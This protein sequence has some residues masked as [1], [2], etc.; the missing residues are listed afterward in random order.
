M[1]GGI[2]YLEAKRKNRERMRNARKQKKENEASVTI[3]SPVPLPQV[4]SSSFSS[5]QTRA[6][7]IKRAEKSLPGSPRKRLEIIGSL[8]QKYKVLLARPPNRGRK[9]RALDEDQTAWLMDF[10]DRPDITLTNPGTKESVY[11]G[12]I[13]GV[14]QFLQKQYLLWT[15]RDLLDIINGS[16]VSG[17]GVNDN[18]FAEKFDEKLSLSQLYSFLKA[19]KQFVWNKNIPEVSCLCEVCENACLFAKGINKQL[20][21]SLPTNPH[22]LVEENS[23]SSCESCMTGGCDECQL[24]PCWS[25]FQEEGSSSNDDS[26]SNDS[27]SDEISYLKWVKIEKKVT[28][29]TISLRRDKAWEAWCDTIKELKCHIYRKRRQVEYYNHLKASMTKHE[30]LIHVDYSESYSNKQQGEIQSA[31]FGHS[32]FSIFTACGYFRTDEG[33][34]L[35]KIPITIVSEANDQSRIAANTCISKAIESV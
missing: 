35:T 2:A 7:S 15:L 23:C 18:S 22:S 8:A 28:K 4:P 29:A 16:D 31:Y 13:N 20:K 27:S 26:L 5:K 14:S 21:L 32:N 1:E 9:F 34:D 17:I 10:L 3:T 12:K 11:I 19:K 30:C 24:P 33:S 25:N 6:R